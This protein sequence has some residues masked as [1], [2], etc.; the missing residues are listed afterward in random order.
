MVQIRLDAIAVLIEAAQ[1]LSHFKGAHQTQDR[2][3]A[4]LLLEPK[5]G[6]MQHAKLTDEKNKD[7]PKTR[8]WGY[9]RNPELPT[10]RNNFVPVSSMYSKS[11]VFVIVDLVVVQISKVTISSMKS[12]SI[13]VVFDVQITFSLLFFTRALR[14]YS[15][16]LQLKMLG[17]WIFLIAMLLFSVTDRSLRNHSVYIVWQLGFF[18]LSAVSWSVWDRILCRYLWYKNLAYA[19]VFL[20]IVGTDYEF[21]AV[22]RSSRLSLSSERCNLKVAR[23]HRAAP[24]I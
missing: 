21:S 7:G 20:I 16:T 24:D 6:A 12:D 22:H 5:G 9:R 8:R 13:S 4:A 17:R 3:R 14:A 2:E 18:T 23:L 1:E 15:G 19:P 11:T 10:F